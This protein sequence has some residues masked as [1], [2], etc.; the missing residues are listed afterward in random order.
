MALRVFLF[1]NSSEQKQA[2]M[3]LVFSTETVDFTR[4]GT[5]VLFITM[6][7]FPVQCLTLNKCFKVIDVESALKVL[8]SSEPGR[9]QKN[10]YWQKRERH[11]PQR[12]GCGSKQPV[13]STFL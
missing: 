1:K 9:T 3:N 5:L 11:S 6:S 10:L 13:S 4:A 12:P 2:Q 7:Q 8:S